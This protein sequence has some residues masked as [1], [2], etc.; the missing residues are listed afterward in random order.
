MTNVSAPWSMSDGS[1]SAS[2]NALMMRDRSRCASV[3]EYSGKACS[4]AP[5][6]PKKLGC[7]PPA[8]TR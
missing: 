7:E 3:S 8:S 2:S 1:R 5:G 4:A 6:V